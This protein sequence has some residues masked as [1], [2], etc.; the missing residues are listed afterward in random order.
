MLNTF[1]EIRFK[2]FQIVFIMER[3]PVITDSNDLDI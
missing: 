3:A 1:N 2:G